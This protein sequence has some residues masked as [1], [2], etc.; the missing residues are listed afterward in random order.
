MWDGQ[1][2]TCIHFEVKVILGLCHFPCENTLYVLYLWCVN[3]GWTGKD[4]STLWGHRS[5]PRALKCCHFACEI[6]IINNYIV[7]V[8][9]LTVT[10]KGIQQNT[11]ILD[12]DYEHIAL[13]TFGSETRVLQHLTCD[14]LEITRKLGKCLISHRIHRR[15]VKIFISFPISSLA[16]L[17]IGLPIGPP[18]S[19]SIC[20]PCCQGQQD[21]GDIHMS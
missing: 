15:F 19:L 18:H 16:C 5:Q 3:K 4:P 8:Q 1:G 12:N 6:Y 20:W 14:Y 7:G 10:V 11:T 9:S 2:R 13:V 21:K 17:A